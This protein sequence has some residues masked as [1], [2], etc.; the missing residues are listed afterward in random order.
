[1]SR[2]AGVA[3]LAHAGA[4]AAACTG[5]AAAGAGAG[6]RDWLRARGQAWVEDPS[7]R[8]ALHAQ[9][10]P[11]PAAAGAAAGVSAVSRHLRAQCAHAAQA[12]ELLQEL[13]QADLATVGQPPRIAALRL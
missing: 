13:A 5:S 8:R 4:L 2:G 11:A 3:G 9:P 7:N 6:V 12:H 10:H 1:L